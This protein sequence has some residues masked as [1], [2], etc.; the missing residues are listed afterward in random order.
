[1]YRSLLTTAEDF[2]VKPVYA[3][4]STE[5]QKRRG[6]RVTLQTGFSTERMYCIAGGIQRE[7]WIY[8]GIRGNSQRLSDI[9][10]QSQVNWRHLPFPAKCWEKAFAIWD[11]PGDWR[12]V[13]TSGVCLQTSSESIYRTP[14]WFKLGLWETLTLSCNV[15]LGL[16]SF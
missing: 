15:C 1:M 16:L 10:D 4:V 5:C 11:R 13:W 3:T 12:R 2:G 6:I 8:K 9:S 14:L 7:R